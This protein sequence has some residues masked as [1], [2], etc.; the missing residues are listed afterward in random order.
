MSV[1]R[2]ATPGTDHLQQGLRSPIPQSLAQA[3]HTEAVE[4]CEVEV[5]GTLEEEADRSIMMIETDTMTPGIAHLTVHTDHAADH[6]C[7]ETETC[8]TNENLIGETAM[9]ADFP[10]NMT[11]T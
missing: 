8:G 5:A 4:L 2:A 10:G 7:D 3:H 1:V 9:T 11:L 6:Q